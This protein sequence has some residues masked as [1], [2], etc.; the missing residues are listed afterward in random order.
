IRARPQ[1]SVRPLREIAVHV[2]P[3]SLQVLAESLARTPSWHRLSD[4]GDGQ[5]CLCQA[6]ARA[7]RV[8]AAFLAAARRPCEP[9]VRDARLAAA[10]RCGLQ[11]R[12]ADRGAC[13]PIAELLPEARLS[14]FKA[15]AVA[16]RRF[17]VARRVGSAPWPRS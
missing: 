6:R 12:V 14:C 7:A 1:L 10:E 13:A 16:V 4:D 2:R 3:A 9:L 8:R 15:R 5:H 17:A 11:R